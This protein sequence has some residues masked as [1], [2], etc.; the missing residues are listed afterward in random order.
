MR[1]ETGEDG[2][3]HVSCWGRRHTFAGFPLPRQIRSAGS[4]LLAAPVQLVIRARGSGLKEIRSELDMVSAAKHEVRLAGTA[5]VGT[6]ELATQATMEYDGLIRFAPEVKPSKPTQVESAWLEI[7]LAARHATLM[8]RPGKWFD[9]PTCAGALPRDGWR[10]PSTAYLW[11]GDEE[12]GLCWFAEDQAAWGLD[13][14]RPGIEATR[15]GDV[16]RL[17]V[18]LVNATTRLAEPR[19]FTWASW[20]HPSSRGPRAGSGGDS[21]ARAGQ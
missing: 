15:D 5:N 3:V 21:A 7:P 6:L 11:L 14:K 1:A 4:D 13:P 16:V 18:W 20:P 17:R 12:R 10:A 9:D 8:H 19:S 2:R